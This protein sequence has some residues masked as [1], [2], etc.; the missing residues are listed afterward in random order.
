MRH[1]LHA[2]VVGLAEV[3]GHTVEH[4]VGHVGITAYRVV[5]VTVI[6]REVE[7]RL[8]PEVDVAEFVA[9]HVGRLQGG[10]AHAD[11]AV[12][13][14]GAERAH[15]PETRTADAALCPLSFQAGGRWRRP[16]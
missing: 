11:V 16:S 15:L 8:V 4:A 10:V 2:E 13:V 1:Q 14:V 3:D 6:S 12:V 7:A 5:T 9:V